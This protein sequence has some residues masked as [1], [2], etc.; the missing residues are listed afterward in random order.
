MSEEPTGHIWVDGER[1]AFWLQPGVTPEDI[2]VR[3]IDP[4]Q[5]DI[6]DAE[7]VPF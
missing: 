6:E 2:G 1:M 3:A 5:L 4:D 7:A